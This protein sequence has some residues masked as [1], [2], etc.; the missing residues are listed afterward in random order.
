V[1]V[2]GV[3]GDVKGIGAALAKM[4]C[5]VVVVIEEDAHEC[6]LV[7]PLQQPVQMGVRG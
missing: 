5:V 6:L 2:R 4:L 3:S 1:N 7:F